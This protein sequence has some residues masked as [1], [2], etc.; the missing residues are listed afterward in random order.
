MKVKA[1]VQ[2]RMKPLEAAGEKSL[3]VSLAQSRQPGEP[4]PDVLYEGQYRRVAKKG[5]VPTDEVS[6]RQRRDASR[7]LYFM[8]AVDEKC[9]VYARESHAPHEPRNS[10]Q[11][12]LKNR[13]AFVLSTPSARGS[14]SDLFYCPEYNPRQPAQP[15]FPLTVLHR[16][17]TH[18]HAR[19]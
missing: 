17:Q 6:R 7:E 3:R 5:R 19:H 4:E 16:S 12:A 14:R 18:R 2:I 8:S 10:W 9:I 11:S 13:L 15:N 1:L